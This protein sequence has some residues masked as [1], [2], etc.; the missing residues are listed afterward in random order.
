MARFKSKRS[1]A[2]DIPA[3]V[4]AKVAER[5]GSRCLICGRIGQSH[6]HYIPRSQ[7][8]LGIEQNVVTLCPDCHRDFDNGYHHN[9]IKVIL[10]DYLRSQ[11]PGWDE[12]ELVFDKW[13][14]IK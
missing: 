6:C 4:K 10:A 5:D 12:R 9:E 3:S 1:N 11:Y 14:E 8:G 2:C 7:G 13:K